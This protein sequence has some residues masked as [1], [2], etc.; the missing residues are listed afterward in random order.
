MERTWVKAP[1]DPKF[2]AVQSGAGSIIDSL[3]WCL[4]ES[5]DAFITPGPAYSHFKSDFLSRSGVVMQIANTDE[6]KNYEPQ[7][8]DFDAA[9][10]EA[11]GDFH[12]DVKILLLCNPCNPTGRIYDRKTL[13]MAVDWCEAHKIH[14]VCDE[15]YAN[16][17]FPG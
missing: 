10:S 9:F 3:A 12:K 8:M 6:A 4:C 5:G 2:I 17:I 1:V 14:L 11:V 13:E 16:S 15:I 7:M